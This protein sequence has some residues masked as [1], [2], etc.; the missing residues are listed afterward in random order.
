MIVVD[1]NND[2]R[3]RGLLASFGE[4]FPITHLKAPRGLSASRN[5]GLALARGD[6][7]A[8]PDDDCHYPPSLLSNVQTHFY[9]NPD[10]DFLTGRTTDT[11]GNDSLGLSLTS[12]AQINRWNVWNCGNSNSIFVRRCVI[13]DGL[14]FNEELGVGASS[15]FQSGEETA[16]LLEALAHGLKGRFLREVAVYHNQV[17]ETDLHRARTYA[18]GFGRVLALYRYPPTFVLVRLLR[19]L[20]R[21]VLGAASLEFKLARYKLEWTVG[22]YEGYTGRLLTTQ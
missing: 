7:V 20:V 3:L 11:T 9:S 12:D 16:F 10:I 6:I 14:R 1:Q 15:V 18:R 8:F 19:P 5:R 13:A 17:A 4:A 2:D 22:V 21:A